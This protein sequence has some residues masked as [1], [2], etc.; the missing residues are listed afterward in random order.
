MDNSIKILE[1]EVKDLQNLIKTNM[2]KCGNY[3]QQIEL[4]I[5]EHLT[6]IEKLKHVELTIH[7]VSNMLQCC[8]NYV[9][10]QKNSDE[11]KLLIEELKKMGCL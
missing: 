2:I 7:D 11:K 4:L 5:G 3:P 1:Q 6:A 10:K 9:N 8:Y